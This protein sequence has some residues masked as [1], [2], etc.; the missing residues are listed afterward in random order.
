MDLEAGPA[1]LQT[2]LE[3]RDGFSRG[4]YFVEVRRLADGA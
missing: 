2:W 3:R 4:A 1:R